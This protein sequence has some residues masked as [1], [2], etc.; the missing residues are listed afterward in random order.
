MD[1][2]VDHR[3]TGGPGFP[4]LLDP[5]CQLSHGA[6]LGG[7]AQAGVDARVFT[8]DDVPSAP[9][10]L[11]A[12]WCGGVRGVSLSPTNYRPRGTDSVEAFCHLVI[13]ESPCRS[14]S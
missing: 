13:A 1:R 3:I 8:K 14:T 7:A 2:L 12:V 4:P 6:P 11:I 5:Q 10:L 9:D